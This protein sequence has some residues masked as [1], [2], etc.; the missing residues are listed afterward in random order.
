MREGNP[1][2]F[3]LGRNDRVSLWARH[4]RP[5]TAYTVLG[6][7]LALGWLSGNCL[8]SG[9]RKGM[10]YL[11]DTRYDGKDGFV[12]RL[13]HPS[14]ISKITCIDEQRIV[15]AGIESCVSQL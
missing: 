6:D 7:I 11:T 5:N 14:A 10:V 15:V 2:E 13:K 12:L 9:T 3:A 8:A 1:V 4:P